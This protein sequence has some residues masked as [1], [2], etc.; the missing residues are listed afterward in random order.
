MRNPDCFRSRSRCWRRQTNMHVAL[1][2]KITN[3]PEHLAKSGAFR[4][5]WSKHISAQSSFDW[6]Y[7]LQC[8]AC[9]AR[10]V[11]VIDWQ[12]HGAKSWRLRS[13]CDRCGIR[14]PVVATTKCKIN[15]TP[16][17][18]VPGGEGQDNKRSSS[19][20]TS[21]WLCPSW[22][23]FLALETLRMRD[24]FAGDFHCWRWPRNRNEWLFSIRESTEQVTQNTSIQI[25]GC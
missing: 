10:C 16:P 8:L 24:R 4:S 7:R 23:A 17:F 11:R 13:I 14:C 9:Q 22:L 15:L 20:R 12:R 19:K 21:D 18:S 6:H 25:F 2:M 3:R 5:G 1:K